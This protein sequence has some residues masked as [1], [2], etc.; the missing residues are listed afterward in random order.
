M[1][2]VAL[3]SSGGRPS[4]LQSSRGTLFLAHELRYG[5]DVGG[6]TG[7][8][9]LALALGSEVL[10]ELLQRVE[11]LTALELLAVIEHR[12]ALLSAAQRQ[13]QRG[14]IHRGEGSLGI[15]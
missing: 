5:L 7:D 8:D 14:G 3:T 12:A 1:H 15:F 2:A 4:L 11:L 10:A 13:L 6:G 9:A